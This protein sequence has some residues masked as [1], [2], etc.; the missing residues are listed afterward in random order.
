MYTFVFD[1][2]Q[3]ER[4]QDL[5]HKG[6]LRIIHILCEDGAIEDRYVTLID[7]DPNQALLLHLL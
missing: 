5:A 3:L 7:C 4:A 1:L 2:A 6:I